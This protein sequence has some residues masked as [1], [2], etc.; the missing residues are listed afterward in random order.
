MDIE[1]ELLGE[2]ICLFENRKGDLGYT[3][4]SI[5]TRFTKISD[6]Y[7]LTSNDLNMDSWITYDVWGFNK[8]VWG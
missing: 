1:I 6:A 5:S 2:D 4:Y 7:M 3:E 8:Y